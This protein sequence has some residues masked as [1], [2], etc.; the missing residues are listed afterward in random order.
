[1]SQM[2][3]TCLP[4]VGQC[5]DT[6]IVA[7]NDRVVITTHQSI[8]A[9]NCFEPTHKASPRVETYKH[10]SSMNLLLTCYIFP[11]EKFDQAT[12]IYVIV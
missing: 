8:S 12:S 3:M 6:M 2:I 10:R 5:F 9:G 7:S 4:M 1:M 11:P